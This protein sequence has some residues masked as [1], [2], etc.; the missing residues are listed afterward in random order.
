M[1]SAS[2]NINYGGK[3]SNSTAYVKRLTNS[4]NYPIRNG[5][6]PIFVKASSPYPSIGIY[7][8]KSFNNFDSTSPLSSLSNN[9]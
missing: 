2:A 8:I 7:N 3:I 4:L 9:P 5:Y 6:L 1:I